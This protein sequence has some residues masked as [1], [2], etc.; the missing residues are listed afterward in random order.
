MRTRL[1]SDKV[2]VLRT[3]PTGIS[4]TGGLEILDQCIYTSYF[5]LCSTGS[6]VQKAKLYGRF[7]LFSGIEIE[8]TMLGEAR[9]IHIVGLERN[10]RSFQGL[11]FGGT[12]E[13]EHYESCARD[14]DPR[15]KK[16]RILK[17][18]L[19]TSE[20]AKCIV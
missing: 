14:T 8:Q 9:G 20:S 13:S 3:S 17:T 16:I 5:D 12:I 2:H 18:L 15:K 19:E 6:S 10:L 4:E 1:S 7:S 11:N